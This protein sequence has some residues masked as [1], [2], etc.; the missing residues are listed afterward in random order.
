MKT[1]LL[2]LTISSFIVS[3]SALAASPLYPLLDNYRIPLDKKGA[4]IGKIHCNGEQAGNNEC[5]IAEDT[6]KLFTIDKSGYLTLRH[7]KSVSAGEG[8]ISYGIKIKSGN[9]IKEFEIVKDQFLNNK[10]IAHR[11]AWKNTG[12]TENSIGSLKSAIEIGCAASE[13]DVWMAA[14]GVP[15]IN[16]DPHVGEVEVES[17]T[18]EILSKI[19]LKKGDFVATLEEYLLTAKNQ[20]RTALVL[21][22]K[23]SLVSNERLME[24]TE[25]VVNMVHNLKMQGWVSYIS[26]NHNSLVRILE[27]DPTAKTAFLDKNMSLEQLKESKMWGID[28]NLS[29]FKADPDLVKKAHNLGLTVN[30]WTV[31]SAE[32]MKMLLDRGVDF[33]TT[34]EP[35]MMLKME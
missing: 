12:T 22:I 29:L 32:D 4:V 34:N 24:L 8:A 5:T 2:S 6:S 27:L 16:H 25:K 31:N 18:S 33:I 9:V 23:S 30:A 17:T 19:P 11:G 1:K 28:F 10:V 15:V 13:F 21:E 14:D 20:N 26:F 3:A 7:N 35:E